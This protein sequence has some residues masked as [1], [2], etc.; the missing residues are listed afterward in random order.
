[1]RVSVCVHKIHRT[2]APSQKRAITRAE[3]EFYEL[4]LEKKKVTVCYV[5]AAQYPSLYKTVAPRRTLVCT[6]A[7]KYMPP[8]EKKKKKMKSITSNHKPS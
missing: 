4:N 8:R 5:P 1:M 7:C 2:N 3:N 6:G